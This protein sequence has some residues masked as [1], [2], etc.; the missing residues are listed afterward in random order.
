MLPKRVKIFR[1]ANIRRVTDTQPIG[2]DQETESGKFLRVLL[3]K[4]FLECREVGCGKWNDANLAGDGLL[5]RFQRL[6]T[7]WKGKELIV[8]ASRLEHLPDRRDAIRRKSDHQFFASLLEPHCLHE[9]EE[10]ADV[11]EVQV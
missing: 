11:I 4:E 6:E 9:H 7:E 3:M 8:D 2:L 10:S 1:S 5:A